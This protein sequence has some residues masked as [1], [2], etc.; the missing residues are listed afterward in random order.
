MSD[1][2]DKLA[3]VEVSAKF[4]RA[5]DIGDLD[6]HMSTWTAD[7]IAFLSPYMGN[8]H[9][10]AAYRAGLET[11]YEKLN[12]DGTRHVITN[13]QILLAGDRATMTCYLVIFNRK[14]FAVIAAAEFDDVL[15]RENGNWLFNSRTQIA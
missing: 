5:F 11:F 4:E 6:M 12:G 14:T 3:I 10:R 7:P 9:D 2:D 8:F 15:V 1:A 13:H